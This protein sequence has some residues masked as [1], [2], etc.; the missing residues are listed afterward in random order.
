MK[1]V[2]RWVWVTMGIG[3][4]AMGCGSASDTALDEVRAALDSATTA[5]DYDAII[6]KAAAA[7]AADPTNFDLTLAL[8]SAYAGR[9]GIEY[10]D[11]VEALSDTG[12]SA[13]AFDAIHGVFVTTLS[14][15]GLADVR[16][17]ISTLTGFTGTVSTGDDGKRYYDQ[18]G[19]F[20]VIEAFSLS[21]LR[22]KPTSTSTVTVADITAADR[23]NVQDDFINADNNLILGGLGADNTIV[24][25]LRKNY[26]ALS[27]RSGAAGFTLEEL[28]D[29]TTCQ[30]S[31]SP[32]TIVT[33]QS[34]SITL[35]SDFVFTQCETTD[36]SL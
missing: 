8:S 19:T 18:L 27:Q 12:N 3:V 33:F 17:A 23:S 25:T 22:A 32:A 16:L 21:T 30:L 14:A 36:T 35:C 7:Q 24:E 10:L 9:A 29:I 6:T 31:D 28:Q 15:T 1:C 13:T 5:S 2:P 4:C 34:A 26:C 11:L 20:Q